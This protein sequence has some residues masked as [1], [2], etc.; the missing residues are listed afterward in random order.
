MRNS[1][2]FDQ[3]VLR[4]SS[5]LNTNKVQYCSILGHHRMLNLIQEFGMIIIFGFMG[6]LV[7]RPK[8]EVCT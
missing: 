8:P 5:K 3:Y 4:V 1:G 2:N 6:A 7:M